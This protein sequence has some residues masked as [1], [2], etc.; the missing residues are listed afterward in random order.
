MGLTIHYKLRLPAAADAAAAKKLVHA[1]RR[2]AGALV[3]RRQLRE[4]QAV[5]AVDPDDPRCSGFV[6]EKR[7]DETF[8]HTVHPEAGWMYRVFPGEG[9]ESAEFGL[10]LY[11]ATIRSGGRRFR[12]GCGGWGYAGFCKT[13]YASL[14]G[15]ANFLRCH[16]AVIDLLVIWKRLGVTVTIQDEG[17]YWP[18]RNEQKLLA[19]VG[20]M[21]RLVAAL[22]GA[23]K[24]AGDDDGTTVKSPIFQHGQFEL[25]EAEGLSRH[26]SSI[27]AAVDSLIRHPRPDNHG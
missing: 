14:H 3:K 8:G 12:T 25:L 27:G 16:K 6:L 7:G 26:G 13:Q 11:P 15:A 1:A 24:D 9:C 21:N 20:D 17:G 5:R 2:R 22:G 18:D 19:E 4:I 23:L 10:C